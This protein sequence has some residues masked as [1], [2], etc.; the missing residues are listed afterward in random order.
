MSDPETPDAST[1]PYYLLTPMTPDQAERDARH[2]RTAALLSYFV[3]LVTYIGTAGRS[4]WQIIPFAALALG[5]RFTFDMTAFR[6]WARGYE[7]ARRPGGG[8]YVIL[9]GHGPDEPCPL[10]DNPDQP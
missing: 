5:L 2:A 8:R 1:F 7:A 10:R 6:W 3:A 4:F 9:H